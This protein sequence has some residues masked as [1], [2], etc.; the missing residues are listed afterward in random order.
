M[1]VSRVNHIF[2]HTVVSHLRSE[3]VME[4]NKEKSCRLNE[5]QKRGNAN[6]DDEFALIILYMANPFHLYS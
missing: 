6:T 5:F 4:M 2:Y 1:L 3:K